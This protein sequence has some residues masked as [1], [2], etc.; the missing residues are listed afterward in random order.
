MGDVRSLDLNPVFS[1][2]VQSRKRGLEPRNLRVCMVLFIFTL[3]SCAGGMTSIFDR[4]VVEVESQNFTSLAMPGERRIAVFRENQF[5]AEA[6]PDVARSVDAS[7]SAELAATIVE[8]GEGSVSYQDAFATALLLTNQR[9]EASDLI[10]QLGW[11]IC[12]AHLN[13]AITGEQYNSLL[14]LL[15]TESL[16]F[17]AN[18]SPQIGRSIED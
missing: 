11:Q 9:T 4:S 7:S 1:I 17:I 16:N 3:T 14:N 6:L 8:Q 13:G 15:V 10:R 2:D 18:G 5:C 12:Q